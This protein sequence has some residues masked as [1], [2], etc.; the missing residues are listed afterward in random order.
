MW[1]YLRPFRSRERCPQ[2]HVPL[3]PITPARCPAPTIHA[4]SEPIRF[5][6]SLEHR[7]RTSPLRLARAGAPSFLECLGAALFREWSNLPTD[8]QRK[9]FEHAT[10]DKLRD[11]APCRRQAA[12][13]R[14]P[15]TLLTIHSTSTRRCPRADR[16]RRC[17][18]PCAALPVRRGSPLQLKSVDVSRAEC[19]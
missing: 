8:F 12:F 5:P 10:S 4:A 9:L 6:A 17:S 13:Y 1:S 15:G 16:V 14:P 3:A 11:A 2:A 7:S 18:P 19:P